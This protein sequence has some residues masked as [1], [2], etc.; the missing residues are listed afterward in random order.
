MSRVVL[1][2]YAQSSCGQLTMSKA[3]VDSSSGNVC[4]KVSRPAVAYM[5][6]QCIADDERMG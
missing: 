5:I 2:S 6:E 4:E 3:K 1:A